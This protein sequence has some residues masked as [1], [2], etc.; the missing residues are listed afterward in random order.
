MSY[1]K[2][3]TLSNNALNSIK[4]QKNVSSGKTFIQCVN[5]SRIKKNKFFA[6]N[7]GTC[8]NFNSYDPVN[9]SG[10]MN[11]TPVYATPDINCTDSLADCLRQEGK[12]FLIRELNQVQSDL[13]ENEEERDNLKIREI[14]I[15]NNYTFDVAKKVYESEKKKRKLEEKEKRST[16]YL[17][18]IEQNLQAMQSANQ[19]SN[20][21]LTDKNRVL[22]T[23]N[24]DAQN[25]NLKLT[26]VNDKI[27]TITQD[28][29]YN[30]ITDKRKNQMIN[31][32]KAITTI[33]IILMFCMVIYYGVKYADKKYGLLNK[34]KGNNF[35][36]NFNNNNN[37]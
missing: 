13:R 21:S 14:A 35:N 22:A 29:Y 10:N 37:F 26:E 2:I 30:N 18:N 28:I 7:N 9:D 6:F 11:D 25:K 34:F 8:Y 31:L 33:I 32:L 23:V 24:S 27:N 4:G 19:N 16:S 12:K 17:Q 1:P 36:N 20:M 3:G 5:I 15:K